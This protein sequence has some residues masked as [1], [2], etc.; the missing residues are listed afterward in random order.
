MICAVTFSF[1]VVV[2]VVTEFDREGA[3]KELQYADDLVLIRETTDE[4]K[5][6]FLRWKEALERKCLKVNLA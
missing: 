3:L 1:A 2:D 5:N 6:K 4:L